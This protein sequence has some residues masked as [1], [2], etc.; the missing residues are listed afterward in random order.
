VALAALHSGGTV[1]H[2][3]G[4]TVQAPVRAGQLEPLAALLTL[5]R[6]DDRPGGLFA[7][8][9]LPAVHFARLFILPGT[10]DTTGSV[11]APS[12]VLMCDSDAPLRSRMRELGEL[13]GI[14]EVFAHC[15]GYP[16]HP[17]AGSRTAWLQEHLVPSAAYYVHR[18]GRSRSQVVAEQR[19]RVELEDVLDAPGALAG[20]TAPSQVHRRLRDAVASRSD[21]AWACTPAPPPSLAFRARQ[22]V[23]LVAVPA[24]LL[25]LSPLLLPAA[26]VC[27]VLIRQQERTD[28]PESGPVDAR[29]VRDVE[30]FED[31][32]AQNPFTAVGLLK[33]GLPRSLVMRAVLMALA[34]A[35]RHLFARDNLAGV[36]SIHFA[37]WVRIDGG[38]R[39]IFASSY[40]GSQESYMDDFIDRLAWGL[41]AAFSNG[42]G[43]PR[44]HWLFFGGARDEAAFKHH[45]RRHQVPTT[46]FYSAYDRTPAPNLDAA[47]DL[48]NGLLTPLEDEPARRWLALL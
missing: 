16:V 23:H 27:L 36:R 26:V 22:A 42:I 46:V 21:L 39:L 40:D 20:E 38:R 35:S 3:V 7:F 11:I 19:L 47:S 45:L 18:I 13:R 33:T 4:I 28:V 30:Q 25:V 17:G 6:S 43:Y 48:R 44:T 8:S 32:T 15:D 9:T 34:Y 37:R 12:L 1:P 5:I 2:Q 31:H 41:N 29:H 24:L 10:V 14:D